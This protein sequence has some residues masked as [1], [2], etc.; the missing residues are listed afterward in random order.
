MVW[1]AFCGSLK[2]ELVFVPAGSTVSSTTYTQDI[3]D[4]LL[5]PFWHQTCK[6]YGW[7]QVVEDGAP[8]HKGV[9]KECWEINNVEVLEWAPQSPDL[10]LIEVLWG[11]METKL[12]E[13]FGRVSD[14]EV[15]KVVLK[16]AWSNIGTSCLDSLIRSM[17]RWLEAVIAAGGNATPY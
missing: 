12:G 9:S 13:T 7:T 16:N 8:G 5:I 2:S 3:L 11:D 10:N 4:P 15:L 17:P 6:E 1:G 14:L